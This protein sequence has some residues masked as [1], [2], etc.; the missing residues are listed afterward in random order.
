[1]DEGDGLVSRGVG[2]VFLVLVVWWVVWIEGCDA[3]QCDVVRDR[4]VVVVQAWMRK[5]MTLCC[6]ARGWNAGSRGSAEMSPEMVGR[7]KR[8]G[9]SRLGEL[10]GAK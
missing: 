2:G 8:I 1:M 9:V 7:A 10:L 4:G 3:M 5:R 6:D